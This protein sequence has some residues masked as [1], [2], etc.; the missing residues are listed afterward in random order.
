M[1]GDPAAFSKGAELVDN[2]EMQWLLTP[3]VAEA[4]MES[5]QLKVTRLNKKSAIISTAIHGLM[6]TKRLH[7]KLENLAMADDCFGGE[8]GVV[9]NNTYIPTMAAVLGDAVLTDNVTYFEL[10][11]VSVETY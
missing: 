7:E 5:P 11:S 4:P 10:L 3:V 2:G 6:S 9:T 1:A 8:A